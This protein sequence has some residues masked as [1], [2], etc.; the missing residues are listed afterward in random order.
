MVNL[1]PELHRKIGLFRSPLN[2]LLIV[3]VMLIDRRWLHTLNAVW[4]ILLLDFLVLD[5]KFF[6]LFFSRLEKGSPSLPNQTTTASLN[7]IDKK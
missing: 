5:L 4:R 3:L 1:D 6:F 2:K 7:E